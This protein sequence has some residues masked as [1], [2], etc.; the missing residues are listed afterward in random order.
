MRVEFNC[1]PGAGRVQVW[2]WQSAATARLVADL[3]AGPYG[4]RSARAPAAGFLA[5]WRDG[6][7]PRSHPHQPMY[8]RSAPDAL[9]GAAYLPKRAQATLDE[10]FLRVFSA[11]ARCFS[12]ASRR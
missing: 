6:S 1:V 3:I 9:R 2:S 11:S 12:A 10:L 4:L 5:P 8:S 7:S